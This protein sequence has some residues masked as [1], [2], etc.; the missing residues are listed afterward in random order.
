[1]MRGRS[2][3]LLSTIL[4]AGCAA[5]PDFQRPVAPEM[6]TYTASPLE[7]PEA[8]DGTGVAVQRFSKEEVPGRWWS[9]FGSAQLDALVDRALRANPNIEASRAALLA[10]Q[11]TAAAQRGA[12]WPQVSASVAPTRQRI[13]DS[14]SSPLNAPANPY[15]LHTAQLTVAYAPDV[16]G[17]NRRLVESL[18][19]GAEFQRHELAAARLSVATNV[20]NAAIQEASLR[21]QI[22]ATEKIVALNE[23]MLALTHRQLAAGAVSQAAVAAQETAT[24]QTKAGL[25]PLRR[26]LAV[27]RDLLIALTGGFPDR[28]IE[29]R[30]ELADLRLP[31]ELP[32]S[33]PSR[34]VE[35]RPDVLAA[36]ALAHAASAQVG[37]ARAARLPQFALTAD[38]GS[39][40]TTVADLFKAG[41]GFWGIAGAVAQPVF[42]GGALAHREAAAEAAYGQAMAQYRATVIAA[43]QNVADALH[44]LAQDEDG[45]RAA[46]AAEQAAERSLALVR[47]QVVL[48]D[49]SHLSLLNAE[50]A[51]RQTTVASVQAQA[52]RHADTAALFQALGGGWVVSTSITPAGALR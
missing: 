47:R 45:L 28:E 6:K 48:G 40:A 49:I 11:E 41:S 26:Q 51:W 22:A 46:L 42:A 43:Y 20:V 32:V 50:Q 30:F 18:A 34:L 29:A 3:L 33:L 8:A 24:A 19:A 44:A 4:A 23:E 27:N 12:Y 14:L 31:T 39:V 16:F 21:G 37:I 5:G 9:L 38:I 25:P 52:A 2:V 17:G 36:E 15:S 13:A 7:R 1:M 35:Q 10:A